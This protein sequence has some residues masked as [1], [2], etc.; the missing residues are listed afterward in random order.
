MRIREPTADWHGVLGVED[1]RGWR[2][3]DD[4]GVFEVASNLGQVFD[5][6]SLMV[7]A[8]FAEKTMVDNVVDVQLVQ[9]RITVLR[10]V[11]IWFAK[12]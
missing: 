12:P 3:V 4:D 2:V 5:V 7:V 1:I 8:T 6:V 11:S 9:Q 10:I